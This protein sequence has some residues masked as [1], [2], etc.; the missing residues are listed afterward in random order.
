[1]RT[2]VDIDDDVLHLIRELARAEGRSIGTVI[3]E[4]ARRGLTPQRIEMRGERPV[5]CVPAG[6]PAI[7]PEMV[8][9][10]LEQD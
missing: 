8:R 9:R 5:F 1:M 2:T 3:S 6:T 7:T 4:L 10:G